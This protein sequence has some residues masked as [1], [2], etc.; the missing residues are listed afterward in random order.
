MVAGYAL[1]NY[2]YIVAGVATY[3]A[4]LLRYTE[5]TRLSTLLRDYNQLFRPLTILKFFQLATL[6]LYLHFAG[7]NR[8]VLLVGRL[9]IVSE[10]LQPCFDPIHKLLP[11]YVGLYVE[12]ILEVGE[13][14]VLEDG[15]I[16]TC[17]SWVKGILTEWLLEGL[18]LYEH[19][20]FA[21]V[22]GGPF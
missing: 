10:F 4:P 6:T 3:F 15:P 13:L 7:L 2:E 22:F 8:V 18:Q 21:Y 16:D 20:P 14:E 12:L 9:N 17:L 11:Y 19:Q 5:H 1:F